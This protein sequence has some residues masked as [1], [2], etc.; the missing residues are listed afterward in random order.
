M[1]TKGRDY[2]G[3][4]VWRTIHSFAAAY[5]PDKKQYVKPFL[6][7]TG[8]L[9]P[10]E[11]CSEHMPENMKILNVDDYLDDNHSLFLWSYMFHDLVNKQ[12][13]KTSPSYETVKVEYFNSLGEK[14]AS[15]STN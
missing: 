11:D 1:S 14:C 13:G 2:W 12:I 5:T 3:P 7:S 10:C 15:C 6:K 9:L 8:A 4:A